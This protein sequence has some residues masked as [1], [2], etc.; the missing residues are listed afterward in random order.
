MEKTRTKKEMLREQVEA[1]ACE[2]VW[3]RG[4]RRDSHRK[5]N[6]SS[7]KNK[8]HSNQGTWWGVT[9]LCKQSGKGLSSVQELKP[10]CS[11]GDHGNTPGDAET[12]QKPAS[13]TLE[14]QAPSKLLLAFHFPSSSFLLQ[15]GTSVSNSTSP[16]SPSKCPIWEQIT[17]APPNP[18]GGNPGLPSSWP[19]LAQLKFIVSCCSSP[20]GL[21]ETWII[22]DL[23]Q[24]FKKLGTEH[25]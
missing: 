21:W 4:G 25:H 22:L 16:E 20:C 14:E 7:H 24:N 5:R 15:W 9:V 1:S 2:S 6:V 13:I 10:C 19:P 3:L 12:L 17:H 23:K 11:W 8:T 18:T